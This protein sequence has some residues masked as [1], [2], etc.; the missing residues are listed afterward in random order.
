MTAVCS[1]LTLTPGN[2]FFPCMSL[3]VS[4]AADPLLVAR[5]CVCGRA[6]LCVDP[7]R[8]TSG[9]LIFFRLT[10]TARVLTDFYSQVLW[11][12]LFLRLEF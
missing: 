10:Q 7:L 8:G 11:E 9:I 4:R 1:A 3:C 6:S 2:P 12:P 5:V